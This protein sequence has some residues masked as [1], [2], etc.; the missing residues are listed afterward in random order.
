VTLSVEGS[1]KATISYMKSGGTEQKE[2]TLPWKADI[3]TQFVSSMSAQKKSGNGS[4][5]T[6][7]ITEGNEVIAESTSSGPY[8][9]TTCS[10]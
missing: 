5:I 6:C 2:V 9:V 4:S 7:R 10:G 3:K 1:G 8:A